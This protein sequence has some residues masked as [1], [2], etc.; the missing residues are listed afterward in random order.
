[1]FGTKNRRLLT[2]TI[3]NLKSKINSCSIPKEIVAVYLY[4]SVIERR[5]RKESDIDI[6]VLPSHKT[7]GEE[8]LGLM[9]RIENEEECAL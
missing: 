8:R 9:A 6:A 4:G 5:L 1:L 2:D 3:I 7:T